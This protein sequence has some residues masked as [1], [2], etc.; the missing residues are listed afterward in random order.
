MDDQPF[1][2]GDH[3]RYPAL[4]KLNIRFTILNL[5]MLTAVV[6]VVAWWFSPTPPFDRA[7]AKDV[8][9]V[10]RINMESS[11]CDGAYCWAS[12]TITDVFKNSTD[13]ELPKGMNIGLSD[14]GRRPPWGVSTVYLVAYNKPFD[15]QGI[16]G[17]N[18]PTWYS[19]RFKEDVNGTPVFTHQNRGIT[20]R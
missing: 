11:A 1:R 4:M 7:L 20:K 19:W 3:G 14:G 10:V 18:T 13:F 17:A 5:I 12:V 6:A 16:F 9:V 2:L 15:R 8:P